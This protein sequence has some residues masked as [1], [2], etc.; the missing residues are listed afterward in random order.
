M[1]AYKLTNTSLK[2]NTQKN[3]TS[4]VQAFESSVIS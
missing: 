4:L 3:Q 2:I 1:V